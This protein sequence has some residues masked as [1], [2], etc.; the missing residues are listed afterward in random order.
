MKWQHLA[1]TVVWGIL[2]LSPPR[3]LN[4][5][6]TE[7]QDPPQGGAGQQSQSGQAT[8]VQQAGATDTTAPQGPGVQ[9]HTNGLT[10]AGKAAKD[11]ANANTQ[12][13]GSRPGTRPAT[14][15][16]AV[17]GSKPVSPG[18]ASSVSTPGAPAKTRPQGG[19][20]GTRDPH[21]NKAGKH[22]AR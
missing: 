7:L 16:S 21:P 22:F 18:G 3:T 4:A 8:S 15:R 14:G 19:V 12:T 1:I 11:Q 17:P 20:R 10:E 5:A 13:G 9:S 2:L 6:V